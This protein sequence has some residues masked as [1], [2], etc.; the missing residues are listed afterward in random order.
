M[1][2]RGSVSKSVLYKNPMSSTAGGL[3]N[4]AAQ[5]LLA[6]FSQLFVRRRRFR[7]PLLSTASLVL[8]LALAC[9]GDRLVRGPLLARPL[10]LKGYMPADVVGLFR[11]TVDG[12]LSAYPPSLRLPWDAK[13][14]AG[15]SACDSSECLQ[16]VALRGGATWILD[17]SVERRALLYPPD[18]QATLP[19]H[20]PEGNRY[21]QISPD[22][23]GV[24]QIR[25]RL[26]HARN[27]K[28]HAEQKSDCN[29]CSAAQAAERLQEL[30][31]TI[32]ARVPAE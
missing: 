11:R 24:W 3:A 16:A 31:G 30:I 5:R 4:K 19:I 18:P 7:L 28:F 9:T 26:I 15:A 17:A 13:R 14:L 32:T 22:S 2:V 21:P 20:T 6:R 10:E 29:D 25:V 8:S 27:A 1:C 23:L 12:S